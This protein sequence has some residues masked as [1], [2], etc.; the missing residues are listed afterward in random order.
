MLKKTVRTISIIAIILIVFATVG[1]IE[2]HYTQTGIITEVSDNNEVTVKDQTGNKWLFE[3][4]DFE[5]G[6]IVK[7]KFNTNHTDS[8]RLD[9]TIENVKA[10]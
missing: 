6:Q 2:T 4:T 8:N 9:D 5:E 7:I 1:Y 3:S 10:L